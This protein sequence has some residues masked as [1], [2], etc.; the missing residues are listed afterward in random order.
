MKRSV[1]TVPGGKNIK[2]ALTLD[3]IE[4]LFNYKPICHG[5]KWGKDYWLFFYLA[6][7]M[8]PKDAALLKYANIQNG[9][10]VFSRSK[11]ENTVRTDPKTISVFITE[12]IADIIHRR[13]NKDKHAG[14]YI[15]PILEAGLTPLQEFD[16]IKNFIRLVNKWIKRV[17]DNLNFEEDVSTIVT[18]HT[19]AT[20]L[21]NSGASTE[22]IQET[23]GHTEKRTTENYLS[24]FFDETKK[25]FAGKLTAFKSKEPLKWV[26]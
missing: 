12:E 22:F 13:G 19:C 1:Y 8:N 25:E 7:G 15:F 3:H 23:L 5:E 24:G 9:F 10:I 20:I 16:R 11:T 21:K 2:K 4:A 6:N 18:R 17:C 26:N 14:N